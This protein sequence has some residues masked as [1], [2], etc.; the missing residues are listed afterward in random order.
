MEHRVVCARVLVTFRPRPGLEGILNARHGDGRRLVCIV[1]HGPVDRGADGLD[2]LGIL[3]KIRHRNDILANIGRVAAARRVR[4][5]SRRVEVSY[6]IGRDRTG[7]PI[8]L[9]RADRRLV[10][11]HGLTA[12]QP[13]K[14]TVAGGAAVYMHHNAGVSP[15]ITPAIE[16]PQQFLFA[17][18][19]VH[20]ENSHGSSAGRLAHGIDELSVNIAARAEYLQTFSRT[21]RFLGPRMQ[22]TK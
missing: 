20:D 9:Y 6:R 10:S 1:A 16:R 17:R 19:Y 2:R 5:R 12:L 18:T 3:P 21:S 4:H 22:P 15:H 11:P 14:S 7:S 13:F 8:G